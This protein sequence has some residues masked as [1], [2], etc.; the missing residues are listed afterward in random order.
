MGQRS[1]SSDEEK[2]RLLREYELCQDAAQNLESTIWQTSTVIGIGSI[3][4]FLLVVKEDPCWLVAALI[5]GL[6]TT[7]N[8]IWWRMARR[9][10]SI[11]HTKFLRMR[12]IEECVGFGQTRYCK[13]LDALP[14]PDN[15]EKKKEKEKEE[16]EDIDK[17]REKYL[18]NDVRVLGNLARIYDDLGELRENHEQ[19]GVQYF[20][21]WFPQINLAAWILYVLYLLLQDLLGQ[22]WA[23]LLS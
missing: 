4:T 5:G 21:K 7:A 19:N 1:D 6:V 3:G 10:W 14:K 9:W 22:Y 8:C 13:Y 18:R 2:E 16:Q 11:Q 23:K 15:S 20:L 12:H 17:L